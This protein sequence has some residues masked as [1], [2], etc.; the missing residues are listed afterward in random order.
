MFTILNNMGIPL[1]SADIIKSQNI[2]EL[3]TERE[4][5]NMMKYGKIL[6]EGM[7]KDLIDSFNLCILYLTC[8]PNFH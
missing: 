8:V 7:E 5:K 1:T 2:G 3:S 4:V 6:K